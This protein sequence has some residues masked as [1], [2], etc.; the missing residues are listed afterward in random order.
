MASVEKIGTGELGPSSPPPIYRVKQGVK[1]KGDIEYSMCPILPIGNLLGIIKWCQG[2]QTSAALDIE[3][4][5]GR[6]AVRVGG[7]DV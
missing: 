2:V 5:E 3:R 1:Q 4:A 7:R 6:E